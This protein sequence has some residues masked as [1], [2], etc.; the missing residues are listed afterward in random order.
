MSGARLAVADVT[1]YLTSTPEGPTDWMIYWVFDNGAAGP[2]E[3]DEITAALRDREQ[4]VTALA[5]RVVEV[6]GN[7]DSPYWVADHTPL[8]DRLSVS[9]DPI[10]WHDA[11]HSILRQFIPG[12]DVREFTWRL[13]VHTDVR[14]APTGPDGSATGFESGS[15][16]GFESGSATVVSAQ[17]SHAVLFGKQLEAVSQALFAQVPAPLRV[18]GLGAAVA[19][20]RPISAGLLG[21]VRLPYE[22]A[23]WQ[24]LQRRA[25]RTIHRA[26]RLAV[27]GAAR[28][29]RLIDSRPMPVAATALLPEVRVLRPDLAGVRGKGVTVTAFVLT[30][31]SFVAERYQNEVG[32]PCLPDLT[33]LVWVALGDDSR[34]PGVNQVTE[35]ETDLCPAIAD[36]LERARA[37][38][39]AL[40]SASVAERRLEPLYQAQAATPFPIHRWLLRRVSG[41]TS[42][43]RCDIAVSS[44]QRGDTS[45]DWSLAG[46]PHAFGCHL[47][48]VMTTYPHLSHTLTGGGDD[49]TVTVTALPTT[50]DIDRYAR[51]LAAAFA[52]LG[53]AFADVA[54]GAEIG[55]TD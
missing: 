25:V 42:T 55:S 23:R 34:M 22:F 4:Y 37:V 10:T 3:I 33:A 51:L 9:A 28:Q 45:A 26:G 40:S 24:V 30:A 49:L 14:G 44:V 54:A 47:G 7:L 17:F 6:P 13:T 16:T 8:T 11:L 52:D 39:A 19:R 46:R 31:V 2:P 53:A 41:R 48:R 50:I 15:A 43:A 38:N 21:L 32:Q 12:I 1:H 36:P 35:I 18:D 27:P 20:P 5:R 29:A